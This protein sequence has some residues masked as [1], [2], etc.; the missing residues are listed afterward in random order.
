MQGNLD[1]LRMVESIAPPGFASYTW[2]HTH[3]ILLCGGSLKSNDCFYHEG[4]IG[5]IKGLAKGG[6]NPGMAIADG[7]QLLQRTE[8]PWMLRQFSREDSVFMMLGEEIDLGIYSLNRRHVPWRDVVF[9]YF[10]DDVEFAMDDTFLDTFPAYELG[11][12]NDVE[13]K[14]W[15]RLHQLRALGFS[16]DESSYNPSNIKVYPRIKWYGVTYRIR[17]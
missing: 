7:A 17:S 6:C 12:W 4:A 13:I 1:F 2:H 8:L 15:N 10:V 11:S 9:A 3:H 5:R 14:E 16:S